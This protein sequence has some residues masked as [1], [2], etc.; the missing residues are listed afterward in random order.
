[1]RK[2]KEEQKHNRKGER[3]KNKNIEKKQ[4]Q[5]KKEKKKQRHSLEGRK[6]AGENFS[7]QMSF[8]SLYLVLSYPSL[9]QSLA[10]AYSFIFTFTPSP[11]QTPKAEKVFPGPSFLWTISISKRQKAEEI[12][13][14]RK[15]DCEQT[16]KRLPCEKK[17]ISICFQVQSFS[18]QK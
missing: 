18:R 2:L 3:M 16:N 13:R 9:F 17:K 14:K 12:G 4:Q 15:R 8:F 11:N 10:R 7:F 1:M 6:G 5:K